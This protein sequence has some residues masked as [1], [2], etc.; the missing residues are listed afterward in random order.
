MVLPSFT[1]ST[2]YDQDI[3]CIYTVYI[4]IFLQNV[5]SKVWMIESLMICAYTSFSILAYK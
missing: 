3:Y 2:F 1:R 5:V 4:N